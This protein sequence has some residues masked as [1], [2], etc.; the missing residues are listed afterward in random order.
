MAE[1]LPSNR[2]HVQKNHGDHCVEVGISSKQLRCLFP[3]H[4]PGRKHERPIMLAAWQEKLTTRRPDLLVRGLIQ[5]DGCRSMN[6][7]H[8][9]EEAYSYPRYTFSNRSGDIK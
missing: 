9:G 7:V 8:H 2:P 5:S 3:Q 6:T 1:V 4:A